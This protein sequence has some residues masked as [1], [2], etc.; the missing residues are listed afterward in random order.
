MTEADERSRDLTADDVRAVP[1]MGDLP[2]GS[3]LLEVTSS[4]TY[5]GTRYDGIDPSALY[6]CFFVCPQR[7][8][9]VSR[10]LENRLVARGWAR[11]VDIESAPAGDVRLEWRQWF[12]EKEQVDLIDF[13]S[14]TWTAFPTPPDGWSMLRLNYSRK[15]TRDF[16]SD[17]E[18]QT[19]LNDGTGKGE[20]WRNRPTG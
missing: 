13:T 18:Y 5:D 8:S 16:A 17:H 14:S 19:W 2:E 1:E 11:G 6:D 7:F 10:W 4:G 15:P 9:E 12:R 3:H 20:R